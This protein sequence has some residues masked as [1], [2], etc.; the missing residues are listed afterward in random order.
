MILTQRP[1]LFLLFLFCSTIDCL[2]GQ[3]ISYD[4]IHTNI[5][6][7][8]ELAESQVEHYLIN[9]QKS[10]SVLQ[11][12]NAY[13]LVGELAYTRAELR[14]AGDA[15]LKSLKYYQEINHRKGIATIN[16]CIGSLLMAISD[17]EQSEFFQ[18]KALVYYKKLRDKSGEANI[19]F[20]LATLKANLGETDSS[21]IYFGLAENYYRKRNDFASLARIYLMTG[22]LYSE[23]GESEKALGLLRKSLAFTVVMN[24]KIATQGVYF[25]IGDYYKNRNQL[26]SAKNY[27]LKADSLTSV[28]KNYEIQSEIYQCLGEIYSLEDSTRLAS[29]YLNLSKKMHDSIMNPKSIAQIYHMDFIGALEGKTEEESSLWFLLF[30]VTS[31]LLIIIAIYYLLIV[32]RKKQRVVAVDKVVH[33][34]E[35]EELR[36]ALSQTQRELVTRNVQLTQQSELLDKIAD[37]LQSL[38]TETVVAKDLTRVVS[39][40]KSSNS[41]INWSE[42]ELSF[43]QLHPQFFHNLNKLYPGLTAN[44]RRLCAFICLNLSNKEISEISQKSVRSIEVARYRLRRKMDLNREESLISILTMCAGEENKYRNN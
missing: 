13:H 33:E 31:G 5:T 17:Y 34:S 9:A 23:K 19:L 44:E 27:F 6:F 39:T 26:D 15:Y 36:L 43:N 21:L 7:N 38:G 2:S 16:T 11:L 8:P 29:N 22:Y 41:L 4:Q 30:D 3:D 18:R 10:K 32:R 24:D 40:L 25:S 37:E 42:F 35:T 28:V 20:N 14:K 1:V 12:A